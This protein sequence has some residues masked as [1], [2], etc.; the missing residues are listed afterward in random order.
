VGIFVLIIILYNL[1]IKKR[2]IL[3]YIEKYLIDYL[4]ETNQKDTD[5]HMIT[6]TIL[7]FSRAKYPIKYIER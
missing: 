7:Y 1:K 3:V 4:N 5:N 6:Q 2:L